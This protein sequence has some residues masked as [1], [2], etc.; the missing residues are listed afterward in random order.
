MNCLRI[1]LLCATGIALLMPT[2][3]LAA[4]SETEAKTGPVNSGLALQLVTK[5]AG[6]KD[7][8]NKIL[9]RLINKSDKELT[10]KSH[11]DF[12]TFAD[13]G[14]YLK[15][16]VN[17]S[18]FPKVQ[19][20]PVSVSGG[21]QPVRE[22][23]IT[24]KPDETIEVKFD[25]ASNLLRSGIL[26]QSTLYFQRPGKYFVRAHAHIQNADG[27]KIHLWSNEADFIVGNSQKQP[28]PSIAKLTEFDDD[29]SSA[30]I[31]IG[32][33]QG[34]HVGDKFV[35]LGPRDSYSNSWQL[36]V[37]KVDGKTAT[38]SVKPYS[39]KRFDRVTVLPNVG[40]TASLIQSAAK[41]NKE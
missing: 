23:K 7:S 17:F 9:I 40:A 13:Y 33:D 2:Q 12:F 24:L 6:K 14:E 32:K 1:V 30:K 29:K 38:G 41:V 20:S 26:R 4:Q 27:K 10:L 16:H 15:A 22:A 19:P 8:K 37:E 28:H 31:N 11:R 39:T 21:G 3:N 34:V 18:S 35:I 36:T 25:D 5:H